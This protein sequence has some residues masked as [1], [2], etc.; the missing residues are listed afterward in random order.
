MTFPP[1]NYAS[2]FESLGY[3]IAEAGRD[4]PNDPHAL[5]TELTALLRITN[6]SYS[7]F[8]RLVKLNPPPKKK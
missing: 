7:E 5:Y 1:N 8:M 6:Q 2:H 3:R 4:H